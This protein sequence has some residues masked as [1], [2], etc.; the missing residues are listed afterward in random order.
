[1]LALLSKQS[2]EED[3]AEGEVREA[4]ASDRGCTPL[5]SVGVVSLLYHQ[6]QDQGREI[7]AQVTQGEFQPNEAAHAPDTEEDTRSDD[8]ATGARGPAVAR[9]KPD[10]PLQCRRVKLRDQPAGVQTE[11]LSEYDPHPV[12]RLQDATPLEIFTNI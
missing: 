2:G 1:M 4:P 6:A 11:F 9:R 10:S 5:V 12:N 8:E 3:M 7:Q